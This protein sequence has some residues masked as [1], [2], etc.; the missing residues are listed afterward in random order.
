MSICPVCNGLKAMTNKCENCQTPIIDYGR[1]S[2][3]ED[4]YSAYEEIDLNKLNN[5]IEKDYSEHLCAHYL[6]CPTCRETKIKLL[7]EL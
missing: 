6:Y 2:D 4:K 5:Q 3:Y 1:I 7:H